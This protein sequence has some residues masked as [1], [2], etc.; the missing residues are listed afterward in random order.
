MGDPAR[1]CYACYFRF[2][3]FTR[4]IR[5]C[6]FSHL[7]RPIQELT[8]ARATQRSGTPYFHSEGLSPTIWTLI[9][10]GNAHA[11]KAPQ[12]GFNPAAMYLPVSE[13]LSLEVTDKGGESWN[14]MDG[15]CGAFKGGIRDKGAPNAAE[16]C[17][18]RPQRLLGRSTVSY[19]WEFR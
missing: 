10:V 5:S 13:T 3:S 1:R 14:L 2:A 16:F 15:A 17:L 18:I 4:T 6:L 12:F 19:G 11:M 8:Q 9:L 7:M